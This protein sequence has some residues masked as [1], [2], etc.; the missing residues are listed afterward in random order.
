MRV[1]EYQHGA[2]TVVKPEG[3]LSEDDAIAFA[4]TLRDTVSRSLGRVVVDASTMHFVDS[5]GLEALLDI[6]DELADA[7]SSLKL[8]A[9]NDTVRDVLDIT[10]IASHFE[11]YEDAPSAVRSF[12]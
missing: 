12:R 8:C 11:H 5:K 7:G 6:A 10:G 9:L 4:S 1:T 2:V 3:S